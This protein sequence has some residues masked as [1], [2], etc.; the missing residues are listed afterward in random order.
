MSARAV[1]GTVA[2]APAKV[3]TPVLAPM[4]LAMPATDEKTV[5]TIRSK[6]ETMSAVVTEERTKNTAW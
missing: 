2:T 1:T 4:V 5:I 3:I 6:A